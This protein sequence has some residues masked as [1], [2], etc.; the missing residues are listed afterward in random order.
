MSQGIKESDWKLYRKLRA[1]AL[2]RFCQRILEEI[3][4]INSDSNKSSHDR[5][6]AIYNLIK[7]SDKEIA[8]TFDDFRRSTAVVQLAIICSL[9]LLPDEELQRFSSETR[10]AVETFLALRSA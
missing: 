4:R 3:E 2:E 8:R 1:V 10:A 5:Y 9:G 6:Q 7:R